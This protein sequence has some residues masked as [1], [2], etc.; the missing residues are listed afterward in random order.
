M[1]PSDTGR[2]WEGAPRHRVMS[3]QVCVPQSD[4]PQ[5]IPTA[6]L[7]AR[8][9]LGSCLSQQTGSNKCV[10]AH[11]LSFSSGF[12]LPSRNTRVLLPQERA[13][14]ENMTRLNTQVEATVGSEWSVRYPGEQL[15]VPSGVRASTTSP[16]FSSDHPCSSAAPLEAGWPRSQNTEGPI[17]PTPVVLRV[18]KSCCRLRQPSEDRAEV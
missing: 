2:F 1:S 17:K 18:R 10:H 7:Q 16:W 4:T 6:A 3:Q 9:S 8:T 5:I 13:R 14:G 11:L 12:F 15:V